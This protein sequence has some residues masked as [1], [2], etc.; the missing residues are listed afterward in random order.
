MTEPIQPLPGDAADPSALESLI[1]TRGYWALLVLSG[2]VGLVVSLAAWLFLELVHLVQVTAFESLPARLGYEPAPW[3]WPLPLLG[4]AG[5]LVGFA[6]ERLPGHGG[7]EPSQGLASGPPALPADLPGILLAALA[8]L[9]LGFVLGPEA[10]LLA[11]GGALTLL[12]LRWTRRELPDPAIRMLVAAAGFAALATVF[13]SPI[14]GAVIVIEAAGLAGAALRLVLLPGLVASGIGSLVF[15]GL[16]HLSGLSS[17]AYAISPLTLPPYTTPSFGAFLWAIVL[18]IG[19]AAATFAV[20]R[21]GEATHAW[22]RPRRL[23]ATPLAGL[24]IGLL[25]ILFARSTG[26]P[27]NLV[28]LSGQEAMNGLVEAAGGMPAQTLALLFLIK[29]LAWAISLGSARGGPTFPALFLGIVAGLLAGPLPGLGETPAIAALM[30]AM[31]VAI[32]RLPLTAVVVALLLSQSGLA[33]APVVILA[34]VAAYITTE[35]LESRR[36]PVAA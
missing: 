5:L 6:V 3:W 35:L 2:L 13:G 27:A 14:I 4:L 18:A 15:V 1:R 12:C 29:G 31:C 34:V 8:G 36:M 21:I 9:G 28:L 25:A 30:G 7:H 16:G 23:V 17:A 32:L 20:A 11:M 19:A 10:P 24:V 33:A 22:V 26:A